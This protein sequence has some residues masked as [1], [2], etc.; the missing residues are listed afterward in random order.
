MLAPDNFLY[1][2]II[3]TVAICSGTYLLFAYYRDKLLILNAVLLYLCAIRACAEFHLPSVERFESASNLAIFHGIVLTFIVLLEWYLIWF[4]VRPLRGWRWEK[5]A[6][7]FFLWGL[8]L[9]PFTL[10]LWW[11]SRREVFYFYEEQIDGYWQ[12]AIQPDFV[13]FSQYTFHTKL[14]GNIAAAV[15]L[16]SIIRNPR[17]RIRQSWL[18]ATFVIFP[19]YY[20]QFLEAKTV[21]DWTIPN[22][23]GMATIHSLI[24]SWFISDYRIFRSNFEFMTK[25]LL[26]SISDIVIATDRH[27]KITHFNRNI[28]P[29]L[30][31]RLQHLVSF[32][33][34]YSSLS[35]KQLEQ[36]IDS[37]LTQQQSGVEL[38]LKNEAEEERI[39]R[40]KSSRFQKGETLLGY[41]FLLTDLTKVRQQEAK[42]QEL[43]TTKDRLFAIIGHDLRKPALAFRGIGKKVN[44][45]IENGDFKTLHQLGE[46]LETSAFR[47][48]RLLD[49]LLNW[50]LH[51]RNVL[52]HHPKNLPLYEVTLETVQLFQST[53]ANKDIQLLSSIVPETSIF[54]D[55]KSLNTIL[56]NV[57]D[58]AIK[59]T[60]PGGCVW[61]RAETRADQVVVIVRDEGPGLTEEQIAQLRS[62][63]IQQSTPGT[64]DEKGAGLG[65]SLVQELLELHDA[66]LD[67]QSQLGKGTTFRMT[68]LAAARKLSER[69]VV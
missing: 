5:L 43:N 19:Y 44:F 45:L 31:P 69:K 64:A 18:L 28:E 53:A 61:L 1:F 58:N 67:I 32:L 57:L 34:N 8:L 2:I 60:P 36:M 52:P 66:G 39:F 24:I 46:Q 29:F 11:L 38:V 25:D 35:Q 54:A 22:V 49:N 68:F 15:L 20:F 27:L 62:G 40:L 14:M 65:L 51:Q 37:L 3:F 16:V 59:F 50:A 23:A 12:F 55:A 17:H 4:Y 13:W 63:K 10:R 9:L 30:Q 6:N 26:D 7:Q 21:T 47:L 56:R 42:L 33:Q 41:T 48:N